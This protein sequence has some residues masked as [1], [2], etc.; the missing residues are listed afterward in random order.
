M[1]A[2]EGDIISV[3]YVPTEGQ[4]EKEGVFRGN[5]KINWE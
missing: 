5:K 1:A 2:A 4:I 3:N